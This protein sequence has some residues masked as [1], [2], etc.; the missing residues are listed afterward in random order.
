M[1]FGFGKPKSETNIAEELMKT[2]YCLKEKLSGDP[3]ASQMLAQ[4][5]VRFSKMVDLSKHNNDKNYAIEIG[6]IWTANAY[7]WM[8]ICFAEE[9]I[10]MDVWSTL[11]AVS[12]ADYEVPAI[13]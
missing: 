13:S 7:T 3:E 8:A 12:L 1:A 6:R 10:E 11:E 4:Q 5:V 9:G 2:Y